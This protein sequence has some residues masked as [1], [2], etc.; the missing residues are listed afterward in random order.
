MQFETVLI[1]AQAIPAN[2][3]FLGW[4][5]TALSTPS[6][7]LVLIAAVLIFV[8]A[9]RLV[10]MK[11]PASSIASFLVLLPLPL[12]IS[13]SGWIYGTIASLSVIASSSELF[14]TN[15][16]IAGG[17][18]SSL[19]S[20]LFAMFVSLPTYV[21]LAYGLLSREFR[22]PMQGSHVLKNASKSSPPSASASNATGAPG[23]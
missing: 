17:L 10:A 16:A 11:R 6:T 12:I 22:L 3:S 5:L 18:A 15:Q 7:V 14:L 20:V 13:I 2:S 8:G 1:L 4:M 9:Y 21:V 19:L 23:F